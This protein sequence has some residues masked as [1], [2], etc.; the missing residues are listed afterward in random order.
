MNPSLKNKILTR[1]TRLGIEP[2]RSL[3]QNFLVS[4]SVV[5]KII[6]KA[7]P[8][9]FDRVIEVGPGLGS[10]TDSLFAIKSDLILVE[11]DRHLQD[12]WEE[13]KLTVVRGDALRV[14]WSEILS[15]S[16]NAKTTSL[17]VSNLPYQISAR[18]VV[19]LSLLFPSFNRMVLM[20]QKEVAQRITAHPSTSSYG[21]LT[22]VAQSYWEASTVLDA[23]PM[24]FFP[25]PN[26]ASRVLVFNRKLQEPA[27]PNPKDYFNLLKLSFAN[28]RKK[29]L[30]KLLNFRDK[31]QLEALFKELGLSVDVRAENLSPQQFI[32]LYLQLKKE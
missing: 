29:L 19:D 8:S 14:N 18:L 21:L 11:L 24:D 31:T 16:S 3:G 15:P 12:F 17:L 1:M 2:K 23:G 6:S 32:D 26:V 22:V 10:L 5:D 25:R 13:Q 30:P 20:F 27:I 9:R 7:D 28:R 4:E